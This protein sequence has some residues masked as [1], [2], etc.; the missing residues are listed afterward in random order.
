MYRDPSQ[1]T[2]RAEGIE[3]DRIWWRIRRLSESISPETGRPVCPGR[4]VLSSL[5]K[6][7]AEC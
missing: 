5:R 3:D 1:H 4:F 6:V 7:L 2:Q